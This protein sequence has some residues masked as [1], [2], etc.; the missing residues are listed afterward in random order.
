MS[1]IKPQ[2]KIGLEQRLNELRQKLNFGKI[3]EL[4]TYSLKANSS[5]INRQVFGYIPEL[6]REIEIS[7]NQENIYFF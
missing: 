2:T 5:D 1:K 4:L 6:F 7:K 3:G